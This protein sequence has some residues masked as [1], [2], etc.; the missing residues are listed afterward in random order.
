M[1]WEALHTPELQVKCWTTLNFAKNLDCILI[2]LSFNAT[3]DI[4]G[5]CCGS[6]HYILCRIRMVLRNMLLTVIF[7]LEKCIW[8]G[9]KNAT[10]SGTLCTECKVRG[11]GVSSFI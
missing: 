1:V 5:N 2:G 8:E 7:R 4:P 3:K 10:Q 9:F 11:L 6:F